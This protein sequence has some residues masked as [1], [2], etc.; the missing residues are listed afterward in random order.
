MALE[1][2]HLPCFVKFVLWD[3]GSGDAT[4]HILTTAKLPEPTVV[5]SPDNEGLR[6]VIRHFL[7]DPCQV[8]EY[9]IIAKMDNDC[10]VPQDYLERMLEKFRTTEA[11][12]LSPN[13]FPSN[14]CFKYGMD[15]RENLGYRPSKI[16]GG[17]WMMRRSMIDGIDI[18]RHD[19]L[20]IKGAVN[21]LY[22]IVI[23]KD[24]KIGWTPDV[25]VQ[26]IGHWSAMHPEHIKSREHL[27]Y[28]NEIGRHQ[29][30]S[31]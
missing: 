14:A 15:D 21:I 25:V 7:F 19:V 17:L 20:G 31:V 3:D 8:G 24:P 9:D 5:I 26:D 18:E 28:Y 10:V 2:M 12:I 22:Q 16:V 27:N 13:V 11:D 23:E 30:W 1:R 29:A 4:S 6:N